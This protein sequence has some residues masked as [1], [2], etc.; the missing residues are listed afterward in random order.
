VASQLSCA[1]GSGSDRSTSGATHPQAF[2]PVWVTDSRCPGTV[3]ALQEGPCS[4]TAQAPQVVHG[5]R[6]PVPSSPYKEDCSRGLRSFVDVLD[7]LM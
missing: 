2:G 5:F 7:A 6:S 3:I 1:L 4:P